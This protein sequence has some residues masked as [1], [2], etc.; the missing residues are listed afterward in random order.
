MVMTERLSERPEATRA[1]AG[2]LA[3]TLRAPVVV[4]LYGDLGAGKTLFTQALARALGVTQPVT[5]PTF[6][7][8][9]EYALPDGGVLY[10]VDLY[11]LRD[12][13]PEAIDLGLEELFDVGIVVIEW[14]DRIAPLLPEE[15]IDVHLAHAGDTRRRITI[16]D[17]RVS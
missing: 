3:R 13:I 4:A 10:H 17:H 15:R 16:Q 6:T 11:R 12:P 5:S 7:L 2:E 14:A 8:I 9:N 1:L